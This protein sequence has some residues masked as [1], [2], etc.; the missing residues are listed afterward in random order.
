M[1]L[2]IEKLI[3]I[4][5]TINGKYYGEFDWY[6]YDLYKTKKM[7]C[8]NQSDKISS[9]NFVST[10]SVNVDSDKLSDSEFRKFV[11]NTL[12]IVYIEK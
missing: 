3:E 5:E 2:T 8:L 11:K 7:T 12:P 9:D 1:K 6:C 4:L 10:I